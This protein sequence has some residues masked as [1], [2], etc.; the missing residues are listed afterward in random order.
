MSYKD[1]FPLR[2]LDPLSVKCRS[3][4][5]RGESKKDVTV[6]PLTEGRP[7]EEMLHGLI[8]FF[9]YYWT[10]LWA[11]SSL[12]GYYKS[13]CLLRYLFY[14]VKCVDLKCTDQYFFLGGSSIMA[15]IGCLNIWTLVSDLVFTECLI[16]GVSQLLWISS[17]IQRML[18]L[19]EF[20]VLNAYNCEVP[21]QSF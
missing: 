13:V 1:K 8:S 19:S 21:K 7:S 18:C 11:E 10:S 20:K 9:I 5:Y 12:S 2:D 3:L 6:N 17:F 15:W 14:T 16:S 4:T